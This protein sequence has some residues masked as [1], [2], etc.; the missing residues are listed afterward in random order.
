MNIVQSFY[1]ARPIWPLGR[2]NPLPPLVRGKEKNLSV[3]FRASFNVSSFDNICLRIAASSLYRVYLNG[4]FFC[5]GPARG[6]HGYYRVDA[7]DLSN[8]LV[9]GNNLIAIE[10]VGYN[11]NSFY[12]LEQPAFL[13]A[14]VVADGKTLAS[15][16]GEG[17]P[18][19]AAVL[20]ERVQKVARYSFQR[21][22]SEAYRLKPGYDNWRKDVAANFPV[23]KCATVEEKKLIP[24]R[25]PYPKFS[26][27]APV[28]NLACGEVRTG[29]AVEKVWKDRSF[30]N[31]GSTLGGFP[32]TELEVTPS[33]ELQHI[34]TVSSYPVKQPFAT[35]ATIKLKTNT[36]HILDLGTNLTG[37][38]GA[39][40]RCDKETRLFFIFDEILSDSDVDFKRMGCINIISYE[41]Q[42]GIYKV[43]SMEPYTLRYL[44]LLALDGDCEVEQVY[45]RE[46]ANPDVFEAHFSSS[47][48]QLNQI[49]EAGRETYRQNAVDIFMDCPS[50]ERAGWL[51]DSFFT[52]RVA[53]DLSGNTLVEKNFIENYLLPDHFP[54]IPDGMLP[55]CY[56]ADHKDGVFIPNWAMWFVVELEEYLARSGDREMVDA[57]KL[58][59]LKLFDYFAPF[60]NEDGLL[61]KLDSWVFVEW[62]KANEL[63]QDVN[64]PTNMLYA[65]ALASAGRLYNLPSLIE[66][67]EKI[68]AVIRQQSFD[69][70][71]FVDNAVRNEGKLKLTNNRTEVCQY[72][73]FFF[74]VASPK[75]HP[76]LWTILTEHFGPNRKKTKAYPDVHLA[77]AFIGNYLRLELLSRYGLCPK[78][79]ASLT[80]GFAL[81][82]DEAKAY[83]PPMAG[84]TGTLWEHDDT[85]WEHDDVRASCNHGFASHVVHV[86]YRDILGIRH[87]D[88][89]NK[90][91]TIRFSGLPLNWCEGRL[92]VGKDAVSLRWYREGDKIY[93]RLDVP[94]DFQVKVENL[95]PN[96]SFLLEKEKKSLIKRKEKF[97]L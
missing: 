72:Y 69:G 18:F 79:F 27:R 73:A 14:E 28:F 81:R 89:Q 13:Q 53:F 33:I 41:L 97:H 38:L 65:G 90:T 10:V 51:C 17:N 50:R 30:T 2:D 34:E 15:T 16:A 96:F 5:H 82:L 22:F 59:V 43:E 63:V 74:D 39:T 93:Y 85:L 36:Y 92:P 32:E 76:E 7:W 49:F 68:K 37:F 57:L 45:L 24:R 19:E 9:A 40:I 83:F 61:E 4:E 21:P 20:T 60:K 11:V 54:H 77:N 67:A 48:R 52:A 44:K 78:L 1:T 86:W 31:I 56:P 80:D 87:L 47:D 46:Y 71:F 42:P 3:G 55:M 95:S 70:Q 75:T 12:L 6:P 88:T 84:K 23:I 29:V 94:A 8:D 91:V 64:Y 66:E 25:V 58:R 62:S 26:R 35:N